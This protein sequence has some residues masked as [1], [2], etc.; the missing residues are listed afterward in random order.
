MPSTNAYVEKATFQLGKLNFRNSTAIF[1]HDCT[2]KHFE[3]EELPKQQKF[4]KSMRLKYLT[5]CIYEE[6]RCKSL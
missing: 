4:I 2:K 1:V 6:F 5:L 3:K